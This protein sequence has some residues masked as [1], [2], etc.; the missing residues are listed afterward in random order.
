MCLIKVSIS[1]IDYV[2]YLLSDKKINT[3]YHVLNSV[4]GNP[5]GTRRGDH[6]QRN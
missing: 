1:S 2:I 5:L 4:T 6:L 3:G